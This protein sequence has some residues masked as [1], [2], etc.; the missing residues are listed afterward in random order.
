MCNCLSHYCGDLVLS[1]KRQ[2][3]NTDLQQNGILTL[4]QF[5]YISLLYSTLYS[6]LLLHTC[7]MSQTSEQELER[8]LCC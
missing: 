5:T 2:S 7:M 1:S 4:S 6:H 3:P 8:V